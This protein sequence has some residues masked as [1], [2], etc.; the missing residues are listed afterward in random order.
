MDEF[1][2]S[3]S[4]NATTPEIPSP[5][6]E[7]PHESL[8]IGWSNGSR[9]E[10][11]ERILINN[12]IFETTSY[13]G[14]PAVENNTLQQVKPDVWKATFGSLLS[15]K[16]SDDLEIGSGNIFPTRFD[17]Y[18]GTFV[19]Y[20]DI[21]YGPV[22]SERPEI[23]SERVGTLGGQTPTF[24]G[25]KD[26]TGELEV[27][28]L[29]HIIGKYE[30]LPP[31]AK[32]EYFGWQ[33][34]VIGDGLIAVAAPS[35][36]GFDAKIF[37]FKYN[38]E[39]DQPIPWDLIENIDR[40]ETINGADGYILVDV[41]HEIRQGRVARETVQV[42]PDGS[43]TFTLDVYDPETNQWITQL[44]QNDV[45]AHSLATPFVS[46]STPRV[47]AFLDPAD[48]P[49][50]FHFTPEG[51]VIVFSES[52]SRFHMFLNGKEQWS[53][54]L[55]VPSYDSYYEGFDSYSP[56]SNHFEYYGRLKW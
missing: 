49:P 28:D 30:L 15:E 52:N 24:L 1:E 53:I 19:L 56:D 6:T 36:S 37:I 29:E 41:I 12:G 34:E 20:T 23:R 39:S 25:Y 48:K 5:P 44:D 22:E 16:G 13:H 54:R 35:T 46:I 55:D 17:K 50:F 38:S 2:E 8:H 18:G 11:T 7:G 31:D 9:G 42:P 43:A 27:T 4:T 14:L 26:R 10:L 51:G 40:S 32:S 45:Q 47:V 21:I 33:I 3:P